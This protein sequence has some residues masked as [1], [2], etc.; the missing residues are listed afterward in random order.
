MRG[1]SYLELTLLQGLGSPR[2][3]A[4]LKGILVDA[5]FLGDTVA[6]SPPPAI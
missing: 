1:I 4:V 6:R 2:K 5:W 3:V